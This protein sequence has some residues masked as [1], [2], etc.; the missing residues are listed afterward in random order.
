M[1]RRNKPKRVYY[2]SD[3]L[4]KQ[5]DQIPNYPLT[6]VEAPS[7]FGKTTAVREYLKINLPPGAREY[8]YTCLGEPA[9]A[10]WRNICELISNADPRIAEYLKKLEIPTM[11]TVMYLMSALRDFHCPEETYLV[12]DNYQLLSSDIPRE[13]LSVFSMHGSPNLHMIFITQQLET[14]QQFTVHNDSIHTIDPAAFFF[15]KEGTAN[16]FLMEGIRLTESELASVYSST[17]GWVSAILLQIINFEETGSFD[18]T[19][20]IEHLVE[21]A[22]WDRLS[23]EEKDF[24][25]SVSILDSF[26]ALQAA[27]MNGRDSLPGN[28]EELLRVNDFIRYY[29]D[30][31]IYTMHSILQDYLRNRFYHYMAPEFRK[32]ILQRAGQTF[33]AEGQYYPAAQFFLKNEDY[34]AILSMPFNSEYMANQKENFLPEFIA[35]LVEES[36]EE[37][38]LKYPYTLLAFCSQM[39]MSGRYDVYK[40]LCRLA[41][42]AAGTNAAL[43]AEEARDLK[44]ELAIKEAFAAYNDI[45]AMHKACVKAWEISGKPLNQ[46]RHEALFTFGCPSILFMY[47]RDSGELENELRDLAAAMPDYRRLTQGHGAGAD[48]V[49]RAE[50]MLMRGDD[51]VAEIL[52]HKA[53]YEGRSFRQTAVCLSAELVLAR[54]AILRGDT[55]SYL[56]AVSNIKGYAKENSNLYILRM[57]DLCLSALSLILGIKD[58]VADWI[59]DMENI[60][61]TLYTPVLPYAQVLYSLLLIMEKRYNEFLGLEELFM[62]LAEGK[63][64]NIRYM[65]PRLYYFKCLAFIKL[66]GGNEQE[67]REYF[68]QALAIALADKIYLPLASQEGAFDRLLEAAK[69]SVSDREGLDCLIRLCKRQKKGVGAIRKAIQAVRSPLTPREREVAVFARDR[70]SAKEIA[71]ELFISEATV[72]TILKSVYSKLD[73]HSKSELNT[74]QF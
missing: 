57:V 5:L 41:D 28:L 36:P 13:L 32:L 20:D 69:S 38:L 72:K 12:I 6:I 43:G 53:L 29:P 1:Q 33:A 66:A 62:D 24:L 68:N 19:A 63:A 50:A 23:E 55:E 26:T 49:M 44:C 60:R 74:K 9:P 40:K 42:E 73:I 37:T 70:L 51:D 39:F 7:G 22:V 52:S 11:D 25:L 46:L 8:W 71:E 67:A 61:K 65:M 4:K 14:R 2:F 48:S 45:K 31:N 58:E 47:W 17:E 64:G 34:E 15:D 54:V 10:A 30:R 18:L 3:K 56:M 27:A 35:A 16:L 59:Y 21:N